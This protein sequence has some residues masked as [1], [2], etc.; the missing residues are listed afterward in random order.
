[1]DHLTG[2]AETA[3]GGLERLLARPSFADELAAWHDGR[4]ISVILGRGPARAAAEMGALTLKE[5]VGLPIESLET[6]QFRHGPLELSGP[7]LAAIVIATEPQ[8]RDLDV[9]LAGELVEGGAAA[10]AVVEGGATPPGVAR[11]DLPPLD[12]ALAP[13][14]SIL[15]AQLLAWKL[16][17]LRGRQP[18]AYLRGSKVTT[19]E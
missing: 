11:V 19:G 5:A 7:S 12:R 16:A 18:G 17:V 13:A 2:A 6:A 15:P 8:T 10:M 3:A 4:S 14:V 1:M 9:R